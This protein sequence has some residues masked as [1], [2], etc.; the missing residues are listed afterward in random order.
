MRTTRL[1]RTDS[2]QELA[3]FWDSHDLA[4]FQDELEEVCEPVFVKDSRIQ[5]NLP[6]EEAQAVSQ[7]ALSKGIS[8]AE[9]IREWVSQ[10]LASSARRRPNKR[11]KAGSRIKSRARPRRA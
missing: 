8:Q 3:E 6:S 5:I 11:P 1:P 10:R 9:L 7:I 2:I 4:D